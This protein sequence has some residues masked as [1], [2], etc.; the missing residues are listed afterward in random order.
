MKLRQNDDDDDGCDYSNCRDSNQAKSEPVDDGH[1]L[2]IVVV[3]P[4][5]LEL[6][7][8]LS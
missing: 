5:A 7:C 1:D 8:P 4:L 2:V 6:T 3:C